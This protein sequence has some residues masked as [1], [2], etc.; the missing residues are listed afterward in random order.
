[1]KSLFARLPLSVLITGSV[2]WFAT[3]T[4]RVTK[5]PPEEPEPYALTDRTATFLYGPVSVPERKESAIP[6]APRVAT[7]PTFVP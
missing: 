5:R 6:R 4:S 1:M 2:V 3:T 7:A